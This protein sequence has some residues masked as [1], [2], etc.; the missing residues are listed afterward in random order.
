MCQIIKL[1][2]KYFIILKYCIYLYRINFVLYFELWKY[3]TFIRETFSYKNSLYR[4]L[5]IYIG[6][7]EKK[8]NKSSFHHSYYHQNF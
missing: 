4:I 5:Y 3:R 6:Y 7:K 2:S 8:H 1:L